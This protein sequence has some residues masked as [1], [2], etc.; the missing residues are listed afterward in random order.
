MHRR[1][2]KAFEELDMAKKGP[3]SRFMNSWESVKTAFKARTVDIPY[4]IGP[5]NMEGVSNSKFYDKAE[6][7]VI[8]TWYVDC[9]IW[10]DP[11]LTAITGR[12]LKSFSNL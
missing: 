8:L 1:F 9:Q 3:G 2:G 12:T 5:L 11:T 7:M 6:N 4:E 10:L